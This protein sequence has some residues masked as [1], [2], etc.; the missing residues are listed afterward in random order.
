MAPPHRLTE[1]SCDEQQF[2]FPTKTQTSED[3]SCDI[4]SVEL[5]VV[6]GTYNRA[7][8]PFA[9]EGPTHSSGGKKKKGKRNKESR[10]L[11]DI[12]GISP[13]RE[14]K[15]DDVVSSSHWSERCRSADIG[16]LTHHFQGHHL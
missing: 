11:R 12:F 13:V 2:G 1:E 9:S 8:G 16:E 15:Y 6:S 3:T 14:K 5:R 4:D 7:A 10:A